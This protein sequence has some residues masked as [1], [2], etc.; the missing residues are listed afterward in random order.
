[1]KKKINHFHEN[2]REIDF[3]K[4]KIKKLVFL[5]QDGIEFSQPRI[6]N[7]IYEIAEGCFSGNDVYDFNSR[8]NQPLF[9]N[10]GSGLSTKTS[11]ILSS[12][13]LM[14]FVMYVFLMFC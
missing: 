2:I 7:P 1:M 6:H 13:L 12:S 8:F 10:S 9:S 14:S 4:K 5:F 3:T 11:T